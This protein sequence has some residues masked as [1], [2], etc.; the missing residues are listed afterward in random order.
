VLDKRKEESTR[1][2]SNRQTEKHHSVALYRKKQKKGEGIKL[3]N[4]AAKTAVERPRAQLGRG[5]GGRG[6]CNYFRLSLEEKKKSNLV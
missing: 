6:R 4:I 1:V 5:Q 2:V 3:S